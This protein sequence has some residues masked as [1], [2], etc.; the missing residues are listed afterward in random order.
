MLLWKYPH[1]SVDISVWEF[2]IIF[3]A[4]ELV[5]IIPD[6]QKILI[7]ILVG[8]LILG[9]IRGKG[10]GIPNNGDK[11]GGEKGLPMIPE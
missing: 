9:Q 4:F 8:L 5:A 2:L 10:Q 3:I 11:K 6:C 7:H 1:V